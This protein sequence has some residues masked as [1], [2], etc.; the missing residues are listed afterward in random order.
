MK[1]LLIGMALLLSI[2]IALTIYF[3]A[4]KNALSATVEQQS[5]EIQ[6][7]TEI[8][9]KYKLKEEADS[10][11]FVGKMNEAFDKYKYL[12]KKFKSNFEQIRVNWVNNLGELESNSIQLSLQLQ[13]EVNRY[14]S[15]SD[16]TD[17][18]LAMHLAEIETL[19]L[20]S[21][22]TEKLLYKQRDSLLNG[23]EKERKKLLSNRDS[24]TLSFK[25]SKNHMVRYYGQT[26]NKKANGIG[27]A[28]WS[29]GGYYF[30]MWKDNMRNGN[31]LYCWKDGECYEGEF[32]NDKRHG[33]GKYLWNNGSKYEGSWKNDQRNG[34]GTLYD[35]SGKVKFKGE[36]ENDAPKN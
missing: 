4:G 11:F 28:T 31:G 6:K 35:E 34:F 17:K 2:F 8:V 30:G 16:K 25:S 33:I 22:S 13:D 5:K 32:L 10:L 3:F 36:W 19:K 12:D 7:Q 24:D 15:E 14:K 21:V 26:N 1:R 23:F 9:G 27:S 20:K 29:T 18:L